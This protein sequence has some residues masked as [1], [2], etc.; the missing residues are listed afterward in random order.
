MTIVNQDIRKLSRLNMI[1]LLRY[2]PLTRIILTSFP[3]SPTY[4]DGN[5]ANL[6]SATDSYGLDYAPIRRY[7]LK[8]SVFLMIKSSIGIRCSYQVTK[9]AGIELWFPAL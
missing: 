1:F 9:K 8:V 5:Q 4:W 7:Q 6:E 3:I 2:I